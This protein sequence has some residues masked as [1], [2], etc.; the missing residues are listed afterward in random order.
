MTVITDNVQPLS[1]EDIAA[2]RAAETVQFRRDFDG[3][4]CVRAELRGSGEAESPRIFTAKQQRMF[5]RTNNASGGRYRMLTASPQVWAV[6]GGD[7]T[8]AICRYDMSVDD[9]RRAE[10]QTIVHALR[11]GDRLGLW[12]VAGNDYPLIT[13]A[14]LHRDE[15]RLV[16]HREKHSPVFLI[17]ATVRADDSAR[18]IQY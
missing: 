17:D 2:L 6:S 10:W 5:P 4:G 3:E 14:E 1:A 11:V 12:W 8:S 15:L 13:V 18:M 9:S 7:L 16:L